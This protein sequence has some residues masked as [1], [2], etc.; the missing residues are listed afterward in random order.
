M[1]IFR[2]YE[3]S[4]TTDLKGNLK[5]HHDRKGHTGDYRDYICVHCEFATSTIAKLK[6]HMQ[7]R[8]DGEIPNISL[9]P[10]SPVKD[11]ELIE[12][13]MS[14]VKSGQCH[15]ARGKLELDQCDDEDDVNDALVSL[16]H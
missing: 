4:Y 6:D 7:S 10:M 16:H 13:P 15:P 2:C 12:E 11:S 5:Q 3:C 14:P 9:R 1:Q 8:H